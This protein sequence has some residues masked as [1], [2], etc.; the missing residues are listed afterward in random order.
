[1]VITE[2]KKLFLEKEYR[3]IL[4]L[5]TWLIIGYTLFQ[6]IQYLPEWLPYVVFPPLLGFC[7]V[8]LIASI[9]SRK[10]LREFSLKRIII[11]IIIGV[12]V[13]FLF[14]GIWRFV[15][16][17]LYRIG[18]I[19]YIIIVSVFYMYGCYKYAVK[20]DESLYKLGKPIN[21]I[22]RWLVFI[23]G[24]IVSLI[25]IFILMRIGIAWAI[26]AP[27]IK[28]RLAWVAV[29]IAIIMIG[30]ALIGI[31]TIF[32]KKLNAWLGI[33]L[34]LVSI[35][36]AYLMIYAFYTLGSSG[37]TTYDLWIQIVLYLCEVFLIIYTTLTIIGEKTEVISKKLK[38]IKPD[39]IL[40]WL[41]FS[42]AAY[43]LA[44][45]ADPRIPAEEINVI[46]SFLLFIPL[47]IIAGI[48]GII[49]YKKIKQ[50]RE[51]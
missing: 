41:I 44:A 24:T 15:M 48:Y 19:S 25:I 7:L 10:D 50:E 42:K 46:L 5:T 47:L 22:L 23:G 29:I 6:F 8:F 14:T 16:F 30:L 20:G 13:A 31:L 36:T 37:N 32:A 45:A 4:F 39:V 38:F 26:K 49:K 2:L 11:C 43:V 17:F 35:F 12:V 27:E 51:K 9:I 34:V 21:T 33:F 1:M 18:I 3:L 28:D 40:M